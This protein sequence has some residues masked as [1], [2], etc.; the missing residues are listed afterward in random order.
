MKK[1]KIYCSECEFLWHR[2]PLESDPCGHLW[3]D[4]GW[5]GGKHNFETLHDIYNKPY[6]SILKSVLEI[7]K[8]NDCK[9][10]KEKKDELKKKK[11]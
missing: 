4:K 3:G 5:C 6:E 2:L 9:W 11:R 7:N 8:N 10:F 1:N